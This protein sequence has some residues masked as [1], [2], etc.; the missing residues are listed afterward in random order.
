MYF[1]VATL[2]MFVAFRLIRSPADRSFDGSSWSGVT[3]VGNHLPKP[4]IVPIAGESHCHSGKIF[5][6]Q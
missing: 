2:Y 5:T 6:K 1:D 3:H 4:Y